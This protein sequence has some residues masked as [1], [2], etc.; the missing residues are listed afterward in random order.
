MFT[1][2]P[3]RSLR[4]SIARSLLLFGAA[5]VIVGLGTSCESSKTAI[6]EGLLT[7]IS[8]QNTVVDTIFVS[9]ADT[10]SVDWATFRVYVPTANQGALLVGK[11]NDI[12]ATTIV[13]FPRVG[14]WTETRYVEVDGSA[15]LDTI[16]ITPTAIAVDSTR[17]LRLAFRRYVTDPAPITLEGYQI[18]GDWQTADSSTAE[19]PDAWFTTPPVFTGA[20]LVTTYDA[21]NGVYSLTEIDLPANVIEGIFAD[22]LS[23]AIRAENPTTMAQ[24]E[25]REGQLL[26]PY[27]LFY[28]RTQIT[29]SLFPNDPPQDSVLARSYL[30][31][32]DEF[33]LTYD[34]VTS[35]ATPAPETMLL[36]EGV[37]WRGYLK[38]KR[39][40]IAGL[41]NPD[42]TVP[43][44]STSNRARLQFLVADRGASFQPDSAYIRIYE[45]AEPFE[46]SA[47]QKADLTFVGDRLNQI[48]VGFDT[49]ERLTASN[50]SMRVFEVADLVNKWWT[51]PDQNDGIILNLAVT[52]NSS[53]EENTRVDALEIVGARLIVTA[54]LPPVLTSSEAEGE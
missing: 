8:G 6:G 7:S 21:T 49:V 25:A 11:A 28:M 52:A 51:R 3:F 20:E 26:P 53:A 29:S 22:S 4:T 43:R 37:T 2:A 32:V 38:F 18:P 54:T 34:P 30:A 24:I 19:V 46:M 13:K 36:H 33:R 40:D 17:Q 31:A 44:T 14:Q 16:T 50:D 39:F 10:S 1:I 45:L 48:G 35:V 15:V 27:L 9:L 41:S 42:G 47:A 5:G 23:F 12:V